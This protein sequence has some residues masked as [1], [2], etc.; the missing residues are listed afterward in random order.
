MGGTVEIVA[1]NA[2]ADVR[3][4]PAAELPNE[5]RAG[6]LSP[7]LPAVLESPSFESSQ[8]LPF[9]RNRLMEWEGNTWAVPVLGDSLVA[10]YR[11]DLAELPMHK[12]KLEERLHH[13]LRAVG[14][15]TW[16]DVAI[17]ADYFSQ[18]STWTPDEPPQTIPRPSL[19]ALPAT[20][21]ELDREFHA[22]AVSFVRPA[23]NHEKLERITAE[24][25][26]QL[27]YNYHFDVDTGEPAI[28][29]PGFVAALKLMQQLQKFRPAHAGPKPVEAFREGRAV[30]AL[31]SLA[32]VRAFQEDPRLKDRFIVC[33]VPGSQLLVDGRSGKEVPV[34]DQEGNAIPYIGSNAWL[35]AVTADASQPRAANDLLAFLASPQVS[36]EIVLEPR[37]GGGPTRQNHLDSVNRSAWFAYG[38]TTERTD[39]MR[40]ILDR[41]CNPPMVNPVYRLRMPDQRAYQEAFAE[42]IRPALAGQTAPEAALQQAAKRWREINPDPATRKKDYRNSVGLN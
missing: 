19:P 2:S 31:V 9:Y 30:F 28:A 22:L 11:A 23:V 36:L 32:D 6:K 42:S 40:Q 16:Q 38:F 33:R 39:Q 14:P 26:S 3:L 34:G 18:Q 20:A 24:E 35:G 17:I 1:A 8:L 5:I 37:W 41:A 15:G 21:S 12:A 10:V 25:R 4:I 7:F 29:G 27:L 13:P